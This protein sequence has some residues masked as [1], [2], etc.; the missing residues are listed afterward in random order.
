MALRQTR[1]VDDGAVADVAVLLDHRV[2]LGKTVH[3]AAILDIGAG[4]D[5]QTPEI[6]AQA[7]RGADVH[8]CAYVHVADQHRARMHIG[9]RMHDGGE[10][11]D[12]IDFDHEDVARGKAFI[13]LLLVYA[14]K[15]QFLTLEPIS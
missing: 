14:L 12:G 2:R 6:A 1:A 7:G 10:A 11:V 15:L 9:I 8:A 5:H 4:L 13:L 3:D